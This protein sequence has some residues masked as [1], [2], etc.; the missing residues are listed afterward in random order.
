MLFGQN[1]LWKRSGSSLNKEWKKKF[2]TLSNS[3]TLSYHSSANVRTVLAGQ[4]AFRSSSDRCLFGCFQD[5][6]QN[7][8]GKEMD[9]LR[10]TV[11]VPG[12]RPPRAVAPAGPSPVPT[13][14]GPGINGLTDGAGAG[15]GPVRCSDV[16]RVTAVAPPLTGSIPAVPPA[17]PQACLA[18]PS[19]VD[20]RPG[21]ERAL[22]RCPSSLS[23]K[24]QSVGTLTPGS[25]ALKLRPELW[26]TSFSPPHRQMPW[27]GRPVLSPG[28]TQAIPPP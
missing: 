5:Y 11:K 3:G 19:A 24:A 8:H 6:T 7:I 27:K 23:T 20:E 4:L 10:V 13:G 26:I 9:L 25:A 12:K 18:T 2:V 1:I 21:A 22:Q 15:A 28:R 16:C 14:S 17:A